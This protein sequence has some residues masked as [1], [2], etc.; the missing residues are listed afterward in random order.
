MAVNENGFKDFKGKSDN[1]KPKKAKPW[2]VKQKDESEVLLQVG[3]LKYKM[4]GKRQRGVIASTVLGLN[5]LLV[6]A[7]LL[8]FYNPSFQ[9]Y[10]YTVGR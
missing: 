3:G 8:Y 4:P 5:L 7:V 9:Q 6:I 1:T 2:T 10:I